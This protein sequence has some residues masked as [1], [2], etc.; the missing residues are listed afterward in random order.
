MGRGSKKIEHENE[1]ANK[2]DSASGKNFTLYTLK[3]SKLEKDEEEEKKSHQYK[4][5][6]NILAAKK[7]GRRFKTSAAIQ[8]SEMWILTARILEELRK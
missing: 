5:T 1:F 3:E 4:Q 6:L 7:G 2:E 8:G